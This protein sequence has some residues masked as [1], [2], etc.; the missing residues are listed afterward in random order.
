MRQVGASGG[1]RLGPAEGP[2]SEQG[3][4]RGGAEQVA[5]AGEELAAGKPGGGIGERGHG[6]GR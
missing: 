1:S 6:K 5:S 4:E 3:R 2:G